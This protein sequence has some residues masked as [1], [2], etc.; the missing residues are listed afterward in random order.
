[1]KDKVRLPRTDDS[2]SERVVPSVRRYSDVEMPIDRAARTA[3][4]SRILLSNLRL[5]EK[6]SFVSA[7]GIE[8]LP[9]RT[10]NALTNR[11]LPVFLVNIPCGPSEPGSKK[12]RGRPHVLKSNYEEKIKGTEG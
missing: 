2:S 1:M 3:Y 8:V 6:A 9:I 5:A 12:N 10:G 7:G 4:R 11:I